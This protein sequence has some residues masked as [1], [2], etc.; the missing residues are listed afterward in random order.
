[1][2]T[3][4]GAEERYRSLRVLE[5]ALK[6]GGIPADNRRP[7]ERREEALA[8]DVSLIGPRAKPVVG[9]KNGAAGIDDGDGVGHPFQHAVVFQQP[10]E[11]E[12]LLKVLLGDEE[13]VEVFVRQP[14]ESADGVSEP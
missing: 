11:A 5:R 9:P 14:G 6:G 8:D 3:L 2:L 12:G 10:T 1:M 7:A 13:T 4:L